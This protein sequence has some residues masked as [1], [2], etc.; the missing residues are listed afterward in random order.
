MKIYNQFLFNGS[1]KSD[2]HAIATEL[3]AECEKEGTILSPEWIPREG[4]EKANYLSRCQDND[5]W[6][7][8]SQI[9]HYL[10]SIWG[11]YT[12]DA[13]HLSKKC[14]RFNS[15]WWVPGTEAVDAFL[16]SWKYDS[17]WLV[18]PPR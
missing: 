18:P 11:P 4:N 16:K 6:E 12:I 10:D 5:D 7:I 1:R 17:N 13:S 14:K 2:I 9:F 8:R 15:R 3:N